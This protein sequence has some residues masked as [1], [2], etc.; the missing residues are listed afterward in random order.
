MLHAFEVFFGVDGLNVNL[1]GRL[2]VG[3]DAVF[4][5]PLQA[6]LGL[7]AGKKYLCC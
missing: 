2:P 3:G 1:L 6:V 4:L 5:L 7:N